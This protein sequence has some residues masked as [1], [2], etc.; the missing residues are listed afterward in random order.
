MTTRAQIWKQAQAGFTLTEVMVATMMTT[1]LLAAGFGALTVSQKGARVSG[2]VGNTQATAR[3]A[4]DMI[5]ADLK[6]AGFGMQGITTPVGG[7]HINGTPSALVPVDNSPAGA[8]F[9]PDSISMVVPMTNSI[10]AVGALWQVFV[11]PAGTIGGPKIPIANI[12]MPA[13][14]TTGMGNAIP[15]GFSALPGNVVSIGGVAGSTIQL[16]KVGG[17]DIN[18][19]IQGPTAFGTGTQ[20]YLVQCI[21]YQVIPPPDALNI[22]QGSSPCLVRGAVPAAL[23]LPGTPP[24]CNQ[25]NAN[26]VPIMDG[27]EDLQLEYACDGCSPTIN[28]GNLDG[29]IDDLNGNNIFDTPDFVTNRNWFGTAAPFGGSMTPAKIRMVQVTIVAR[30]TQ[31][32]QGMGEGISTNVSNNNA[33]TNVSDHNHATGVFAFGDNTTPAQQ[34]AYLQFRRRV[35]TRTVE[36]RN[37]RAYP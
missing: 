4:L 21:T 11:P 22:C 20:V 16:A 12:P 23:I 15:G 28:S 25:L 17:L 34:Q 31:L 10:T 14:A 19:A 18:P 13:N 33:I 30:Q 5:T 35:Q 36:L 27:V 6:L 3:N 1:A 26:C 29:Q 2:Q 37:M 32:D 8:D 24:N 9:G 7:C